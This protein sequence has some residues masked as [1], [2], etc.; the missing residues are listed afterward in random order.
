MAGLLPDYYNY[1][2]AGTG[3]LCVLA[4]GLRQVGYSIPDLLRSSAVLQHVSSQ[5]DLDLLQA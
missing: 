4:N 3:G 1:S 5:D 2:D